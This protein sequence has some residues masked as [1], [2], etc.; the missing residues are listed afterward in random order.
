MK[1]FRMTLALA[2]E[3]KTVDKPKVLSSE[4]AQRLRTLLA[5]VLEKVAGDP[6]ARYALL[7]Q[8]I[9]EAACRNIG[10]YPIPPGFKLSVVIPVYNEERWLAEPCAGC[11]RWKSRR[12][13][14][15]ST[16][17]PPTA[18]PVI[19]RSWKSSTTTSGVFHQPQNMGEG[20]HSAKASSTAPATW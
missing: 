1:E 5:P 7:Q 6:N 11:R 13:S 9:G 3:N 14:F 19:L 4:A 16:T 8:L 17:A 20:R 2:L 12:R 15:S 10:V 18:R